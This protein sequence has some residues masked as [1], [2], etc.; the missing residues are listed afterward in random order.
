[1][2]IFGAAAGGA[3]AGEFFVNICKDQLGV[4]PPASAV[5]HIQAAGAI[6]NSFA[7][8]GNE[9]TG[10]S[11]LSNRMDE[12]A[13]SVSYHPGFIALGIMALG[14]LTHVPSRKSATGMKV[15][16]GYQWADDV[17]SRVWDRYCE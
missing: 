6:I 2:G 7:G 8:S 3:R 10:A 14:T 5:E 16:R 1:M 13:A 9:Y 4:N 15:H 17:L 12:F 11:R